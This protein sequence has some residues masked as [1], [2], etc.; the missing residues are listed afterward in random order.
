MKT[1]FEKSNEGKF[2]PITYKSHWDVIR[3]IDEA[4]GVSYACK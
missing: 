3:K 1:E 4:T 2:L